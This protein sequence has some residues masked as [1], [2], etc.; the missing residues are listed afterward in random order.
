MK[1]YIPDPSFDI[2]GD[3]TVSHREY[4]IAKM[5]DF[6]FDNKLNEKE[7]EYWLKRLKEGFED[8]LY[9]DEETGEEKF[10]KL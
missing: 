8:T 10:K 2:N 9:W 7:K 4:A 3:G 1:E 5:F 6:D